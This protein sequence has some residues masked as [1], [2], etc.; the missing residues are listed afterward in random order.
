MFVLLLHL[1]MYMF[2]Y[3]LSLFHL[4]CMVIYLIVESLALNNLF[5]FD[6]LLYMLFLHCFLLLFCTRITK[7][8]RR[9]RFN[10]GI[11]IHILP[12]LF[13]D[14]RTADLC[15]LCLALVHAYVEYEAEDADHQPDI[16]APAG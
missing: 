3:M 2:H 15:D 14:H 10:Q 16:E 1:L 12:D 9:Q 8:W 6:K 5:C 11:R 4:H 13:R 7:L